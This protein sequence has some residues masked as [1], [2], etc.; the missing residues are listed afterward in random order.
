[1][2]FPLADRPIVANRTWR[3]SC[4]V[5]PNRVWPVHA[6]TE[7]C[8]GRTLFGL[9]RGP[10]VLRG[11]T[12]NFYRHTN[13]RRFF[14]SLCLGGFLT[15]GALAGTTTNVHAQATAPVDVPRTISYQ[16][17]LQKSDHTPAPDGAYQVHAR[18]YADEAGTKVVWEGTYNANVA[19]GV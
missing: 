6:F 8:R 12:Q 10:I 13:M 11:T 15:L 5:R 14:V 7:A 9:A 18:F 17:I 16:G 1:M 19:G 4:P 3:R 2:D